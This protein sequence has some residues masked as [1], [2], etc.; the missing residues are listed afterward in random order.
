MRRRR[1]CG[2][3]SRH[4]MTLQNVP[5]NRARRPS[6]RGSQ[7]SEPTIRQRPNVA[8]TTSRANRRLR[9]AAPSPLPTGPASGRPASWRCAHPP[10]LSQAPAVAWCA[11][12]R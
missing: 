8:S 10:P 6:K 2:R 1:R 5:P 7:T 12:A 3:R 4:E 9:E 11:S